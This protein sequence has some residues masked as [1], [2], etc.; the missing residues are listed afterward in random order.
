MLLAHRFA[1]AIE[2]SLPSSSPCFRYP[3]C[4]KK[5]IR[6]TLT[7][8]RNGMPAPRGSISIDLDLKESLVRI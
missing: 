6:L 1:I 3:S 2:F 8:G 5:V 7:I 4:I